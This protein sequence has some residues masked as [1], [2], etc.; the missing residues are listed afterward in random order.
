M[1]RVEFVPEGDEVLWPASDRP[2]WAGLVNTAQEI[3]GLTVNVRRFQHG[4]S[5]RHQG[6]I[7]VS[8]DRME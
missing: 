5:C 1:L 6:P 8:P 3:G 7:A 2:A 4:S